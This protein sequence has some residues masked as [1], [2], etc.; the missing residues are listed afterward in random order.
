MFWLAGTAIQFTGTSPTSIPGIFIAGSTISFDNASTILGR[1][2]AQTAN[3]IF[4]GLSSSVNAICTQNIVCYRKG[5]LILTDQGAIPI[6]NIQVGDNVVTKGKIYNY[7]F[8]KQNANIR[9]EPV[10][11]INKF[12]VVRLDTD[13]RPICI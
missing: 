8:V 11:W 13:S 1:L 9:M 10:I 6:E 12:Q 4:S 3:I 7:K 5:T 2:Y